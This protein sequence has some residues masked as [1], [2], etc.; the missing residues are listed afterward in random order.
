MTKIYRICLDAECEHSSVISEAVIN[1]YLDS[2]A[3][4]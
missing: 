1:N 3:W 4:I 2:L